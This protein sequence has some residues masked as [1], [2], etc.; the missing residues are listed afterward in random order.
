MIF[1]FT[2]Y[3]ASSIIEVAAVLKY[4]TVTLG[5]VIDETK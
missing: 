2:V 1:P 3:I 5:Q 4:F